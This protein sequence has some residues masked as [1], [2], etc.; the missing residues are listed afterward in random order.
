MTSG[1]SEQVLVVEHDPGGSVVAGIF[2]AA[3]PA[4]DAAECELFANGWGE[5]EVVETHP[6][7]NRFNT[8]LPPVS[9]VGEYEPRD[10]PGW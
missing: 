4:I 3:N 6:Q 1:W 10:T 5:K 9:P 8:V 7:S 2:L